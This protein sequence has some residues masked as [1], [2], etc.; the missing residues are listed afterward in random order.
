MLEFYQAYA[1]Y[2]D[3]MDLTEDMIST[4]VKELFGTTKLTFNEQEIDFAYPLET[5]DHGGGLKTNNRFLTLPC[6]T[7][8]GSSQRMAKQ[9]GFEDAEKAPRGKLVTFVFEELCEKK[10]IQAHLYYPV[11]PSRSRRWQRE[12]KRTPT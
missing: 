6:L 2:E 12:T 4:L 11:S 5:N 7:T 8:Q 9:L 10:L 3:L 1:N